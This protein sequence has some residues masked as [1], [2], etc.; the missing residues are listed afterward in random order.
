MQPPPQ[1]VMQVNRVVIPFH[2]YIAYQ[3]IYERMIY[4]QAIT[5]TKQIC[6]T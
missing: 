2:A 6:I 3:I 1:Q 5:K 4:I